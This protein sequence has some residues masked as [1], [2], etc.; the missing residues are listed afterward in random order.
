MFITAVCFIFLIKLRWPKTKSLYALCISEIHLAAA[1]SLEIIGH[2]TNC[3]KRPILVIRLTAHL[4]LWSMPEMV[5]PRA[6]VFRPLVKG[7]EAL[8]TR[9]RVVKCPFAPPLG[10]IISQI[11]TP[12]DHKFYFS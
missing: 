4:H 8:G 12:G 9:L 2:V 7:N 10:A 6:R 3:C 11:P 5:A 1:K